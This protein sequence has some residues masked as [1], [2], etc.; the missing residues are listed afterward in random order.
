VLTALA[1]GWRRFGGPMAF[2]DIGWR[3][4]DF[5]RRET[6]RR[7]EDGEAANRAGREVLVSG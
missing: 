2:E 1:R 6:D 4:L 7:P 5:P 3:R